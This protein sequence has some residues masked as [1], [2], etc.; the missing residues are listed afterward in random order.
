MDNSI[1]SRRTDLYKV[2]DAKDYGAI[3]ALFMIIEG[4]FKKMSATNDKIFIYRDAVMS[5][6]QV[7]KLEAIPIHLYTYTPIQGNSIKVP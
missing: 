7:E 1:D 5:L 4:F 6:L 3:V 2:C